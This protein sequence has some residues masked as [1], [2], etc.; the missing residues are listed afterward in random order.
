MAVRT[1][2]R[3]EPG[4]EL[5]MCDNHPDIPAVDSTDGGGK[6]DLKRFC[7]RCWARYQA[8]RPTV[9]GG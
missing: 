4:D 8:T 6:H 9:A 2:T 5:G 1:R 3:E 7:P